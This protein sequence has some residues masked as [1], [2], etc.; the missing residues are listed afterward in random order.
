MRREDVV[1]QDVHGGDHQFAVKERVHRHQ[2]DLRKTHGTDKGDEQRGRTKRTNKGDE[3]RGRT[4]R[5]D[6]SSV[7][8]ISKH[9]YIKHLNF[10]INCD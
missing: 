5:T 10:I 6:D 1:Q 7:K 8:T 2:G 9:D 3:Q 4:K